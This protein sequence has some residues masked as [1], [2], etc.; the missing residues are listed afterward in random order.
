MNYRLTFNSILL[1]KKINHSTTHN[2]FNFSDHIISK[3]DNENLCV[4][5]LMNLS[6]AFD[7]HILLDK[8]LYYESRGVALYWFR[9]YLLGSWGALLFLIYI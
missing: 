8:P 7:H 2:L 5:I 1:Q 3:L 4:G 6:K 9:S